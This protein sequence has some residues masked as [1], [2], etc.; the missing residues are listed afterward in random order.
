MTD[1]L[2]TA[3]S[4][5]KANGVF[6]KKAFWTVLVVTYLVVFIKLFFLNK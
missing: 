6:F 3:S 5:I 4:A 2:K 1:L